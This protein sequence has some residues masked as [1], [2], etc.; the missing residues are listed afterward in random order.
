MLR[1]ALHNVVKH[2]CVNRATCR[3]LQ[4]DGQLRL[5]VRDQGIGFDLLASPVD[6]FGLR[7][8]RERLAVLGGELVIHTA[9]GQ[10]TI[11]DVM[12]P[13]QGS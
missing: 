6:R 12:L 9:P 8:M 13:I 3:L 2:S 7:G 1:E 4:A 11:V 5:T 10:G